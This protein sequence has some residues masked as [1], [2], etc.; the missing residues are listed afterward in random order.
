[1]PVIPSEFKVYQNYPNPF[2]PG[3]KIAID[4]PQNGNVT[5]NVYNQIGQKVRTLANAD[6]KSSGKHTYYF[7][8]SG[9]ATGI[10][11]FRVEAVGKVFTGK[12]IYVK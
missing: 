12:M 3:T 1:M 7:D 9:L 10:Y 5:I 6:Y 11:F 2:N 4:L 8:A